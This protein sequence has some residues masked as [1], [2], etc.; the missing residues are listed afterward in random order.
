MSPRS[1]KGTKSSRLQTAPP[2]FSWM[3]NRR[4]RFNNGMAHQL[5]HQRLLQV[6]SPLLPTVS[7]PSTTPPPLVLIRYLVISKPIPRPPRYSI[8]SALF[9]ASRYRLP[10]TMDRVR[11]LM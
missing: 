5:A 4:K 8:V 6:T 1:Q 11:D 2:P 3:R 9:Y 10:L 7:H